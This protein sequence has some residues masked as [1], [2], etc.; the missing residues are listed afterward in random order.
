MDA[1]VGRQ[2]RM[3]RSRQHSALT[4][5]DGI[6]VM[7]SENL[8][9]CANSLN[10][11]RADEHRVEGAVEVGNREV[12]L[13][14]VDLPAVRIASNVD[15]ESLKRSLIGASVVDVLCEEDHSGARSENGHL[16]AQTLGD[17]IEQ[18]GCR[19]Q[20]GHR[21]RL[22]PRHDEGVNA[23]QIVRSAHLLG[24]CTALTQCELVGPK[25]SL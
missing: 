19:E 20:V 14:A 23:I 18:V 10:A 25:R 8:D 21:R 3:E 4:N 5:E 12:R 17:G 16:I 15:I 22:S 2:L 6:A 11:W 7:S 9:A 1:C 13:E 24:S